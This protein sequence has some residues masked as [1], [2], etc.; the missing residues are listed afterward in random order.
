MNKTVK[1]AEVS[2]LMTEVLESG[3][4]VSFITAGTSMLPLLRDRCDKVILVKNKNM[5]QKNDVVF[6]KRDD[7]QYVLHRIVG[8][9]KDKFIIRGDNLWSNE[10]GITTKHIIAIA[11]AFERN[12]KLI[13]CTDFKYK[14]YCFCLPVIRFFKRPKLSVINLLIKIKLKTKGG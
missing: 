2:A 6:Y 4:E 14:L 11:T 8:V 9:K 1:L 7:G 13:K 3:G 5:P 10:H 12:G